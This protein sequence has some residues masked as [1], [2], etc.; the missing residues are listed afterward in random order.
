MKADKWMEAIMTILDQNEMITQVNNC[1]GRVDL[2]E[3]DFTILHSIKHVIAVQEEI[4]SKLDLIEHK[5]NEL[6]K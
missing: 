6:K 3:V 2:N 5:L 4:T 1:L